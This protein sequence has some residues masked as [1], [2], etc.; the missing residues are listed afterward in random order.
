M[1]RYINHLKY[2]IEMIN[3]THSTNIQLFKRIEKVVKFILF[4][5]MNLINKFNIFIS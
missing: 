2:C 5:E 3:F 1:R 4:N